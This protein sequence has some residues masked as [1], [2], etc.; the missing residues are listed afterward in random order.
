[1]GPSSTTRTLCTLRPADFGVGVLPTMISDAHL[2]I[3]RSRI[4]FIRHLGKREQIQA[5]IDK[6]KLD[7]SPD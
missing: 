7:D 5:V 3:G 2:G 4:A 1:M 6:D